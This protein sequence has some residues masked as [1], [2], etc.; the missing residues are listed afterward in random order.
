[1]QPV[2]RIRN[3]V[4]ETIGSDLVIH[5]EEREQMHR[6]NATL[7]AVWRHCDG[8]NSPARIAELLPRELGVPAD[9]HLVWMSLDTLDRLHL[10]EQPLARPARQRVMSR[11]HVLA[12]GLTG[13]AA[14]LLPSCETSKEP[15]APKRLTPLEPRGPALDEGVTA[16]GPARQ[17]CL[18]ACKANLTSDLKN[19]AKRREACHGAARKAYDACVKAANDADAARKAAIEATYQACIKAAGDSRVQKAKCAADRDAALKASAATLAADLKQC[20]A[21]LDAANKVCEDT[22]IAERN[23]AVAD[24]K[25]CV[26]GC[27]AS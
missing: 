3:V 24:Y 15:S 20:V 26:A 11:R 13:I 7:A 25:A 21:N 19:A 4:V 16:Q 10:L 18:D 9:E 22:Y 1:M 27:P 17:A 6:L 12:L 5:D 8:H 2:K 23:K 14:L